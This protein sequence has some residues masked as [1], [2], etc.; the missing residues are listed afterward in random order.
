MTWRICERQL[1]GFALLQY[2]PASFVYERRSITENL[3]RFM[4]EKAAWVEKKALYR[5]RNREVNLRTFSFLVSCFL[6]FL[7]ETL[8]E[9][10]S[11][12]RDS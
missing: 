10:V 4:D 11:F 3:H 7:I 6:E 9:K 8:N 5:N 12:L 2:T 1:R